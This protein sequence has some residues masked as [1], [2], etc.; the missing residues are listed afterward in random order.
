M[1]S[2]NRHFLLLLVF[3]CLN[4]TS[5]HPQNAHES[6]EKSVKDWFVERVD[7]LLL[8]STRVDSLLKHSDQEGEVQQAF[9]E[10]R[11]AYKKIEPLMEQYNPE[12]AKKLNGPAIDKHDLHAAERKVWAASGFQVVEEYL[13][14]A[15]N[16]EARQESMEQAAILHGYLQVYQNDMAGLLLSEQNIFE[17]LRLEILRI[18]SLGITGFDS[19]LAL[20]SIPEAKAALNGMRS[21]LQCYADAN[22]EAQFK[23][24]DHALGQA[25]AF[26]DNNVSFNEFDRLTFITG[27]LDRISQALFAFQQQ[28]GVP[29]S[30]WLLPVNLGNLLFSVNKPLMLIFLLLP[31]IV[32][33]VRRQ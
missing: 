23:K 14:P 18:M 16:L 27:H 4:C 2:K 6:S 25:T 22:S 1:I 15:W 12:L 8:A 3:F 28:L 21:I 10:M 33:R 19:P 24:L 31:S 20:H 29:N 17:A 32:M 7:Q 13:F 9:K 30:T 26:L 5:D 11:L